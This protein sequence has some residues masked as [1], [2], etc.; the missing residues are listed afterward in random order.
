MIS[1]GFEHCICLMSSGQVY[2]WGYGGSGC[3]GHGDYESLEQPRKVE[4]DQVRYATAGGYHNAVITKDGDVYTWG[5]GDVGQLGIKEVVRDQMGLVSL[6]PAKVK[7]EKKIKQVAL[8]DAHT[9]I[10]SEEGEVYSCGW[11]DLG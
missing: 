1:T 7:I 6:K 11:F 2:T 10:L 3:L 8:G 5:R 9:L 4:M